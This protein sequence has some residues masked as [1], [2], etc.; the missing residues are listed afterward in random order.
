MMKLR[1][2]ARVFLAHV[3]EFLDEDV[4]SKDGANPAVDVVANF[5]R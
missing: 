1:L 2:D 4:F 5:L 3:V